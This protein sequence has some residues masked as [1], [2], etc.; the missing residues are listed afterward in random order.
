V[1]VGEAGQRTERIDDALQEQAL[2][3]FL[4]GAGE[5]G[6]WG[7]LSWYI[8]RPGSENH[9]TLLNR[10]SRYGDLRARPAARVLRDLAVTRGDLGP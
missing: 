7:V 4:R 3:A 1:L 10:D 9:L 2:A 5:Q 6:Y 8:D